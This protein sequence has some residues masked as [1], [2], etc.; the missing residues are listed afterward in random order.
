MHRTVT[1]NM[2]TPTSPTGESDLATLLSTLTT[3]L[4]PSTYVFIALP[5]ATSQYI[6]P[7]LKP[8]MTFHETEGLTVITTL[9]S[10]QAA[11]LPYTFPCK[12]ITLNI[13]SSL[14][15]VGFMAAV[16]KKLT[17]KGI[18]VNPVSGFY[19]DYCFV[20][21]GRGEE[22][23][24]ALEEMAEDARRTFGTVEGAGE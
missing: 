2:A 8:I 7:D 10:A 14:E 6:L 19:H 22:A 24:N 13:H 15:A 5:T 9:S 16:S 1:L 18:G 3:H 11:K 20:P 4:S 17:E 21:E 23:V 12:M